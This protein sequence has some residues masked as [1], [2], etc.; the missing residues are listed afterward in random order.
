MDQIKEIGPLLGILAFVGLAVLVFLLVQQAREVRRLREWA[1][2]APER[3]ILIAERDAAEREAAEGEGDEAG[4]LEGARDRF[5]R[6]YA[7]L[8][9]VSPVDPRFGLA[10]V[11]AAVAAVLGLTSVFGI[12]GGDDESKGS[13]LEEAGFDRS[14]VRVAVLNGTATPTSPAIPGLAAKVARKIKSAGYKLGAIENGDSVPKSVAM[15]RRGREEEAGQVAADIRKSLGPVAAVRMTD[16]VVGQADGA[17][18][19]L[20]IGADDARL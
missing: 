17:D 16:A 1:G 18:V 6:G 20:I 3:A 19:A 5:S 11:T 7:A 4:W 8:D 10:F 14:T 9:R 12:F 15:F 13:G 2:R